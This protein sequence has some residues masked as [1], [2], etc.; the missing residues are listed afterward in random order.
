MSTQVK[1]RITLLSADLSI[2]RRRKKEG[3]MLNGIQNIC[4]DGYKIV[5]IP[6]S[7]SFPLPALKIAQIYSVHYS[8][9]I[10]FI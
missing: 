2:T 9:I 3:R 6:A 8:T 1:F 5:D 7:S 10:L 4:R